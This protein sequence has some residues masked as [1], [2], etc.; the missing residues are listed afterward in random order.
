MQVLYG[1]GSD[2]PQAGGRIGVHQSEF[3]R[4]VAYDIWRGRNLVDQLP[5]PPTDLLQRVGNVDSAQ[6]EKIYDGIGRAARQ[7]IESALPSTWSWDGKRVLDFGCGAGRVLRQF[8]DC[9][10][11][12]DLHGCDI[13]GPSIAWMNDNLGKYLKGV[14]CQEQPG[15]PFEND[16]FALIYAV[17]VFTHLTEFSTAWLVELRRTLAPDGYLMVTILDGGW[18]RELAGEDW[19]EN[20]IG[21]N[22]LLPGN[23]WGVGGPIV[24]MSRWWIE[25]HWGRAF[26]I[27]EIRP[28]VEGGQGF[29]VMQKTPLT[30]SAEEIDRVS[31]DPREVTALQHNVRQLSREAAQL[32]RALAALTPNRAS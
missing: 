4:P 12:A 20:R 8:A 18:I 16:T 26:N 32:R 13:H 22:A 30:I 10:D 25:A 24:F 3:D 14:T 27:I 21:F 31:D 1:L 5:Y 17:S 23:P 19:D 15:L 9:A 2:P 7:Q 28:G 29:V 11:M 6:Q